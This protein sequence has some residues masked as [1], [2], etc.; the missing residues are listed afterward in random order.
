MASWSS[1]AGTDR[2]GRFRSSPWRSP[3][4]AACHPR[5]CAIGTARLGEGGARE[6]E[7]APTGGGNA[8]SW[9]QDRTLDVRGLVRSVTR[10]PRGGCCR[11]W[12]YDD[13]RT[14]Q[15]AIGGPVDGERHRWR[16]GPGV[17]SATGST[18][19]WQVVGSSD[20]RRAGVDYAPVW[21]FIASRSRS[22]PENTKS[23]GWWRS[24]ALGRRGC[25]RVI[26]TS[27]ATGVILGLRTECRRSSGGADSAMGKLRQR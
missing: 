5:H 14:A 2:T 9:L 7:L 18:S 16:L 3:C 19:G 25:G 21:H 26:C 13:A 23:F 10:R 22:D 4:G 6:C 20:G 8:A 12:C 15:A 1:G 24:L 17:R 27:M 11:G